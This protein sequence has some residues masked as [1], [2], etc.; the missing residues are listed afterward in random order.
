[1]AAVRVLITRPEED[2]E[3]L[4]K[5]LAA[6]GIGADVAP[7]IRIAYADGPAPD[8]AGVQAL[9]VTSANG[10]RAFA[11]LASERGLKVLAVGDASA[12]AARN[13]GFTD[14]A[15]AGGDVDDL[16]HLTVSML[17]PDGGALLHVAG[18]KV[19][20]DLA[21]LL[22]TAGFAYRRAVLYGA[23]TAVVLPAVA[24]EGLAA[25]RYDGVVFYS[26]RTGDTFRTLIEAADMASGVAGLCAYCLSANVAARVS[27]LPW[28]RVAVAERPDHAAMLALFGN[29]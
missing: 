20:G 19:A 13:L 25:G 3:L 24:Q 7:L 2:A 26:P 21:G 1:M 12:R 18:S 29:P 23:E 16:A 11:R 28:A 15:S 8:L 17:E 6:L 4:V 27:S 14:V 22:D 5:D 9:L 10:I